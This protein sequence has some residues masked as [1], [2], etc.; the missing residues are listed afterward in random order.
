V[1]RLK[2]KY[3]AGNAMI[4]LLGTLDQWEWWVRPDYSS[5]ATGYR[6]RCLRRGYRQGRATTRRLGP[7]SAGK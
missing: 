1:P 2:R 7:V 6:M 4:A 3:A 5:L